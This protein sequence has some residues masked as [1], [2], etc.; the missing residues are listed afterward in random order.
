M[1]RHRQWPLRQSS[2]LYYNRTIIQQPIDLDFISVSLLN[3]AKAFIHDNFERP[4]FLLLSLLQAH[5]PM[6]NMQQFVNK[7]CR[8]NF[9]ESNRRIVFIITKAQFLNCLNSPLNN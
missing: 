8:G 5:T 9:W 4:F 2:F 3:D 7:S 1:Q 6:F